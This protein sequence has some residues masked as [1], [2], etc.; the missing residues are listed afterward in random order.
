M[1]DFL[2]LN[3]LRESSGTALAAMPELRSRGEVD[4][5]EE[6]V[7]LD[8]GIGQKY[9]PPTGMPEPPV[10]NPAGYDLEGLL[11][12][13]SGAGELTREGRRA[14]TR[15]TGHSAKHSHPPPPL[16]AR[17]ALQAFRTPFALLSGFR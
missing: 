11:H 9:P 8:C 13:L 17:P 1:G 6:V 2:I 3:A 16:P 7:V 12:R 10:V 4:R 5:D 15:A 14:A